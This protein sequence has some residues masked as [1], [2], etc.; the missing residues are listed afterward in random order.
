VAWSAAHG[1][2]GSAEEAAAVK[3]KKA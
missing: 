2:V 3:A 1:G